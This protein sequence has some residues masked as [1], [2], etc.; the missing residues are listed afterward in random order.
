M[1]KHQFP[2]FNNAK[3]DPMPKWFEVRDDASK[4]STE[5]LIYGEIGKSWWDDSGV[6]AKEFA[7]E[8]K[9]I[10]STRNIVVGINSPGG[11]VWD[12]L[13]IYNLLEAR[14]DKVTTRIDGVAASMGSVIAMAGKEVRIPRNAVIM[15]HD[16]TTF[17]QGDES[18]M[19]KALEA[20]RAAKK[21][22]AGVYQKKTGKTYDEI[23]ERMTAES[24]FTGDEAKE[25]GLADTVIDEVPMSASALKNILSGFRN[26]PTAVGG[27]LETTKTPPATGSEAIN[28]DYM[29]R[30][31]VIAL[32]KKHGIT[33]DDKAT[34]EQ[35][36]AQ[37]ESVLAGKKQEEPKQ[38]AT[39]SKVI[40][41]ENRFKELQAKHD[42][43]RKSRI[44]NAVQTAVDERRIPVAQ[45]AK[46]VTRAM[47]DETV[48]TDLSELPQ[49]PMGDSPV[50]IT[51]EAP[52]D[53]L[54]GLKNL[55]KPIGLMLAGGSVDKQLTE[56]IRNNAV[57][58]YQIIDKNIAKLRGFIV[59][60][61]H[62]IDS[63]LK[64]HVIMTEGMRAFKRRIVPLN[65][66]S[67]R[68]NNV[69]LLGTDKVQ[70]PYFPLFSTASTD[71]VQG[72]GYVMAETGTVQAKE[73]TINK[74][75]YQPFQ[76]NSSDLNRQP[77]L[78]VSQLFAQRVEQL[79]VDVSTDVLSNITVANY[80][81]SAFAQPANA[82]DVEDLIDI[83]VLCDNAFWPMIGRS[84]LMKSEYEANLAKQLL[85]VNEAGSDSALRAGVTGR[86]A[87]FDVFG[88]ASIP[89]NGENLKGFVCLPSALLVATSP[90]MPAPGVRRQLVRYDVVT[91]PDT[92][93][94]FE[95]RY[96]GNPDKDEDRE[97]VECNYGY[98]EGETAA[99]MRITDQ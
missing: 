5:I 35:L 71:F 8:L 65:A 3:S 95:Y 28:Q 70:V 62:S 45:R 99:L 60:N 73:V 33:V 43:E 50:I 18:M 15:I 9:A 20:L 78:S 23:S 75:K 81:S 34:D 68:F 4:D 90:I 51:S 97:V 61:A 80:A 88:N 21:T 26:Q 38:S 1:N 31:K 17:A 94:S 16:P 13:A 72:D 30:A 11:S 64:Q 67:T 7:D 39:D 91:D 44:E 92:G 19:A 52:N 2:I 10:P 98:D 37:L 58:A 66:F 54:T 12:G 85:K 89:A 48:L 24:Y 59:Q 76:F 77:Y 86:I 40:D 46:W 14:R 79:A 87:D 36:E 42:N 25:F 55:R 63:D 49:Q 47:A 27:K 32:L 22:I 41:L 83:K 57:Q 96:W 69:A 84:A 29:N 74:R 56:T 53:V 93:I 82:F 6:S